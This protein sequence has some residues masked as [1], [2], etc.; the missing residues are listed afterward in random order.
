MARVIKVE[1]VDLPTKQAQ[2]VQTVFTAEESSSPC[3]PQDD[4]KVNND[5]NDKEAE[6]IYR[7]EEIALIIKA[8]EKGAKRR[9]CDRAD[10]TELGNLFH[11]DNCS[12][13]L[14]LKVV[15][16]NIREN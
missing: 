11:K 7:G 1:N 13:I 10:W 6:T 5:A 2:P 3:H 12:D 16:R 4:V 9:I 14:L 15:L 8:D